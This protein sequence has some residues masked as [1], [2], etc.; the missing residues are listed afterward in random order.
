MEVKK[1]KVEINTQNQEEKRLK[2]SSTKSLV[3]RVTWLI[4]RVM[5][6]ICHLF[7]QNDL[8]KLEEEG[9]RS[10]NP[11]KSWKALRSP[12]SYDLGS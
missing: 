5:V 8:F 11:V 6:N 12:L 1:L 4:H 9:R 2:R 3:V 7:C 10:E